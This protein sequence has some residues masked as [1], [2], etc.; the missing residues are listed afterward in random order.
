MGGATVGAIA[1]VLNKYVS[2]SIPANPGQL[3][4]LK[5]E[6][7]PTVKLV[8]ENASNV[9]SNSAAKSGIFAEFGTKVFLELQP[10]VWFLGKFG[11][12]L[13]VG[14]IMGG[15]TNPSTSEFPIFSQTVPLATAYAAFEQHAVGGHGG[16]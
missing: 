3:D 16:R 8:W 4:V 11:G 15:Q 12:A 10:L 7:G 1:A 14:A 6:V 5:G 13:D 9:V 2:S